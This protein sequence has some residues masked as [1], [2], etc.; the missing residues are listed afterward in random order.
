MKKEILF[1]KDKGIE[2]VI[3]FMEVYYYC[4]ELV[5]YFE[6]VYLGMYDLGV[7]LVE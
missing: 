5:D 1:L 4:K 6:V 2:I 7:F 3:V